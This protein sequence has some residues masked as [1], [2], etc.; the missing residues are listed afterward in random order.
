LI[1]KNVLITGGAGYIGSLLVNLSPENWNVTVLD[2]CIMGNS[3]TQFLKKIDFVKDD[4]RNKSILDEMIKKSDVVI[5]LA[6]IVGEASFKKNSKAAWEINQ[7]ATENIVDLIKN[8]NKKLVFMST[9]S[10]YGFNTGVCTEETNLNPVDDYSRS[11]IN[12]E[13]YIKNNLE[14]YIIFRLGTVYGWS[15]RMRFDIII[16]KIIGKMLWN[17]PIEIFGGV[18]WRPFI[19]VKDAVKALILATDKPIRKEIFNLAAEN[20]QLLKIAKEI[21]DDIKIIPEKQDNRSYNVENH[22]IKNKLNWNPEM[23]IEKTINEFKKVQYTEDIYHNDK[24][25]YS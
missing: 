19:H 14:N 24:W 1:K 13:E 12:S 22:K 7:F 3:E 21:T 9:C 11:K 16:N 15:P 4:I 8:Y 17:E 6:G 18:Q 5:H 25:D 23:N 20:H 10:V 2:N